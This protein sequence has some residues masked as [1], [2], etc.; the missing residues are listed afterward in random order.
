M[1]GICE[2][3]VVVGGTRVLPTRQRPA[4]FVGFWQCDDAIELF[5]RRGRG[6]RS[7]GEGEESSLKDRGAE[8]TGTFTRGLLDLGP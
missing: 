7:R 6:Q 8:D 2:E 5:C 1:F 3:R 4:L